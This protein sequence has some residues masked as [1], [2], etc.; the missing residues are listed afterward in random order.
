MLLEFFSNEFTNPD[1]FQDA[2]LPCFLELHRIRTI[3][4]NESV[5]VDIL[6]HLYSL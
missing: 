2:Q 5:G 1:E 4:A 3:F 6:Q